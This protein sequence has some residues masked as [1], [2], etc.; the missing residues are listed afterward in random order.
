MRPNYNRTVPAPCFEYI[1]DRQ[2]TTSL[3]LS[4]SLLRF[5]SFLFRKPSE[6]I[7]RRAMGMAGV[8]PENSWF[9]GDDVR[10]DIEGAAR[11]GMQPIWFKCP[12]KCT[13][14][15]E[16]RIPP[17]CMYKRVESWDELGE[18]LRGLI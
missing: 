15:P 17:Q 12:L 14:K 8:R 18:Y 4:L 1:Q 2:H 5:R 9:V 11:A 3:H 6:W 16:T 10:C 13:Y 7:F